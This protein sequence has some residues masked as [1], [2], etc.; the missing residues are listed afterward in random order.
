MHENYSCA[1]SAAWA[2]VTVAVV[3]TCVRGQSGSLHLETGEQIYRTACVACHGADGKGTPKSIAGFEP[4]DSFPD[5]TRCDQTTA[6]MDSDWR[7]VIVH[8]GRLS[9]FLSDHA[10]IQRGA[11]R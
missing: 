7:A 2:V 3:A 9:R 1:K 11:Q 4:P 6:E 5:F 10:V 8:G